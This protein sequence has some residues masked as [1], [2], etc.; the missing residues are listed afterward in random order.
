[1]PYAHR[2]RTDHH[3]P[4]RRKYAAAAAIPRQYRL[5]PDVME[6]KSSTSAVPV[7]IS[8]PSTQLVASAGSSRSGVIPVSLASAGGDA[9][10]SVGRATRVHSKNQNGPVAD[11]LFAKFKYV[12]Q[13]TQS[14]PTGFDV[15]MFA[16]ND[17]FNCF[18]GDSDSWAN[19][20]PQYAR[21]YK[22][23]RV[24]ASHIKVHIWTKADQNQQFTV[25]VAPWFTT[26]VLNDPP[27]IDVAFNF[28]NQHHVVCSTLAGGDSYHCLEHYMK[29]GSLMGI[30][31]I[32]DN[33]NYVGYFMG[34]DNWDSGAPA[35]SPPQLEV[36][37]LWT[38]PTQSASPQQPSFTFI[39]EI[40][41]YV[42]MFNVNPA[43]VNPDPVL[44]H[45]P[46]EDDTPEAD[47]VKSPDLTDSVL[48]DRIVKAVKAAK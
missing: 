37:K 23:F 6:K 47:G 30:T 3:R 33:P 35:A 7:S 13:L 20:F 22:N 27:T 45:P 34:P 32:E 42:E 38:Y 15:A 2:R 31:D 18:V 41:Y 17:I 24:Y 40:E 21:L 5:S 46:K 1:M 25:F 28:P 48:V 8:A 10:G 14:P 9:T 39:T 36:W 11:R 19:Y 26:D 29:T 43:N 44:V 4:R 16:S 12:D